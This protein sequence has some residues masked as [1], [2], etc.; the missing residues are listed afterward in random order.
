MNRKKFLTLASMSA[1]S[2][3]VLGKVRNEAGDFVGDCDTT[4]DILGPFYR[5][6]A[7]TRY[8]MTFENLTGTVVELKGKVFQS[9]CVTPIEN[10]LVEI[11][12]C[13][14]EGVYDNET[15]AF[16]HRAKWKT[17]EKGAYNFKTILP[18]KY[19]NGRL[20][21]PAHIHFRVT[22]AEERE[23][24]S[25]IYFQGDPHITED[26]WASK[27]KAQARIL[28]IILEDIKGSLAVNFD[29]YL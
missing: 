20:Y 21:R 15:R 16:R 26:P 22:A 19:L 24:V 25:Q 8:D 4:N 10:A 28:P 11:W 2:I 5:A 7:P 3:S 14:T 12:H 18:G 9:D 13:D 23:L 6:N 27:Q 17:N 1:F 29:I